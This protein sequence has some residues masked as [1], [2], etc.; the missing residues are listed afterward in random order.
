MTISEAAGAR[1]HD[2]RSARRRRAG[3]WWV[4][5]GSR[6][7]EQMSAQKK[8]LPVNVEL[9][10]RS[11]QELE[12]LAKR[13]RVDIS[14]CLDKEELIPGRRQASRPLLCGSRAA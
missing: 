3:V 9:A 4:S 13:H 14:G 10:D 12:G 11:L 1:A 6:G 8:R 2:V 5:L 7:A